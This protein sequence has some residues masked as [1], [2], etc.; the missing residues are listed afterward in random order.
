MHCP[1]AFRTAPCPA[2]NIFTLGNVRIQFITSRLIRF[3]WSENGVFEDRQTLAVVNRDAGPVPFHVQG[4]GDVWL[5]RSDNVCVRLLANTERLSGANLSVDF[6]LNG[7]RITWNPDQEDDE[8][9]GGTIRTLDGINGNKQ[10]IETSIATPHGLDNEIAIMKEVDLGKGFVSRSGWSLI[11]DSKT[12]AIDQIGDQKWIAPRSPGRHQDLYL[13]AYGHEYKDA[14]ADAARVFGAQ[15]LPPRYTL[16]YWWSRYWAYSDEEIENLVR[17]FEAMNTP[18][19]VVVLDMDWHLEGWT[20]YTWDRRYFPDP[21]E[22]LDWLRRQGLKVTLNLHP[23]DGVGKHEE[24]FEDMAAALGLDCATTERIP[25]RITD[26]TYMKYY[27]EILHQPEEKRGVDF[28]WMDWQQGESTE[29]PGLDT[30]PWLNQLHWE[31]LEDRPDREGKR[32]LIF[33][34]FGGYGAGR[35]AIGFSGDTFSNWESLAFQPRFTATASN[36]LYGHWSHDIGG[37]MP[38]E[39]EPEL[40]TRWM[41][42]GMF[43]PILRTHTSKNMKAERRVWEYPA[44]YSDI[45]MSTIRHRYELVPYIYSENRKA[46]DSG[47]SLCRPMYYE[48]PESEEAYAH[49]DQYMFGDGMLVAPVVTPVDKA[50]EMAEVTVW[51]PEGEWFDTARGMREQGGQTIARH[52]LIDEIP[53]FVRPGT[54]IAGQVCPKRLNDACYKNL[55]MSIY[56]GEAGEYLLYEDDGLSTDYLEDRYASIRM[57]H[58]VEGDTRIVEVKKET[59]HFKGFENERSLEVRLEGSAPPL[60]VRLANDPLDYAYRLEEVATGWSYRARTGTVV[61]KMARIDLARGADIRLA[62]APGNLHSPLVDGS[63]GLFSRMSRAN[64]INTMLTQGRILHPDERL[65]QELAHAANRISRRPETFER[66]M[67]G[68]KARL[69]DWCGVLDCLGRSSGIRG[70]PNNERLAQARVAINI[71]KSQR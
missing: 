50:C 37:H 26:P 28:W 48:H 19:D 6:K 23:A 8:N 58:R 35:Y 65:G 42:F 30:L 21:D 51:L 7:E 10:R 47:I 53:V 68:V 66:E 56:G 29:M 1:N 43:S 40:Y 36:V 60:S 45:M 62:Y 38:G 3:E 63:K 70:W 5:L 20:G 46:H 22:H 2:G 55:V 67:T 61:V 11:D 18:L 24:P 13:L 34:R 71:L 39:I 17:N 27:F 41:Q 4:E 16:G 25:F 57:S 31:N 33:S 69:G 49:A 59:G 9:L 64:T 52:Y 32:A 15:P 44:P 12:I 14:L 54:V